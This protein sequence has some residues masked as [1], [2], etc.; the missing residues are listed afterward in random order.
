[1]GFDIDEGASVNTSA[2]LSH[3]VRGLDEILMVLYHNSRLL[4][5]CVS[6]AMD[7]GIRR[8]GAQAPDADEQPGIVT[9]NGGKDVSDSEHVRVGPEEILV[10]GVLLP[11]AVG[12]VH[13]GELGVVAASMAPSG[14][15][16]DPERNTE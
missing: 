16:A 15:L 2:S 1:M 4:L 14:Q 11:D 10:A 12:E 9:G 6:V 13:Q 3:T 7:P 8:E 5:S